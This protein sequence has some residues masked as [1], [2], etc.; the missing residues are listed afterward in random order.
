METYSRLFMEFAEK[1]PGLVESECVRLI[2]NH[3][4]YQLPI[5][6]STSLDRDLDLDIIQ[7]GAVA[8]ELAEQ[9]GV[10]VKL[11][12]LMDM[13]TVGDLIWYLIGQLD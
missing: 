7:L 9:I 6:E 4:T 3:S 8:T 1:S 5:F 13:E 12:E 11:D 2:R 10:S